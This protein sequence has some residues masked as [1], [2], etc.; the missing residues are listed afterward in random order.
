MAKNDKGQEQ[1]DQHINANGR[2]RLLSVGKFLPKEWEWVRVIRTRSD[3][4]TVWL[5]IK[6]IKLLVGQNLE[7]EG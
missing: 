6:R 7:Q 5:Q 4:D 1:N 3:A 2:A